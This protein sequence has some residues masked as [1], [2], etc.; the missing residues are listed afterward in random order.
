MIVVND[1]TYGEL[2]QRVRDELKPL[3]GTESCDKSKFLQ[4]IYDR[5]D[6]ILQ[7]PNEL[8]LAFALKR[9]ELRIKQ[10]YLPVDVHSSPLIN[11]Y[12]ETRRAGD[13]YILQPCR[14]AK[15]RLNAA[16]NA[17]CREFY[18]KEFATVLHSEIESAERRIREAESDLEQWQK[19]LAELQEWQQ[20]K[21]NKA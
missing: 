10:G 16:S 11:V 13:G 3:I 20:R 21:L 7:L 6:P 1:L 2:I 8:E 12:P 5:L 15:G 19:R 17:M 14:I 18:E 9:V 4:L